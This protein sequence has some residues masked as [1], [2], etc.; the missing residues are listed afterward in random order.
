MNS[1]LYDSEAMSQNNL[2]G[3]RRLLV[4]VVN[5]AMTMASALITTCH[6]SCESVAPREDE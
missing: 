6:C 5:M 4:I 3:E 2:P 1:S